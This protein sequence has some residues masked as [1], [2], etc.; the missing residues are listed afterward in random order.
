MKL[1][2]YGVRGSFPVPGPRTSKYGGNTT[3]VSIFK[4]MDGNFYRVNVD[5][6]TGVINLGREIV[7]NF[8]QKKEGMKLNI[9]FTH[10]HPDH[11]QGFPFFAPNYFK[12]CNISLFGMKTLKKHVGMVL[13]QEMLPPTFPIEYKDL[14]STRRHYQLKDQDVLY[15]MKDHKFVENP[16]REEDIVFRI[17]I[18]QAFAPSHPQ[19]GSMY[20]KVT[21]YE[22]KKN[23]VCAW[24]LESHA[25]GDRRVIQFSQGADVMIHDTQY[26]SDEYNSTQ[27]V[28]QGFG[29]SSYEMAIEN[30]VQSDI[31]KAL[32]CIHYNP[33]HSDEMLD[34]IYNDIKRHETKFELVMSYEGLEYEV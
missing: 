22:T 11:T 17:D 31:K 14:K 2:F 12:E 23:V 28:V 15:L 32:I 29:H 8:F 34:N 7:G 16:K 13:E 10:L 30:A 6:G 25:G 24:D 19:Q 33:S 18:M 27:M 26:T 4:E 21:D 1:K 20:Y 5:S 3:C 9:F